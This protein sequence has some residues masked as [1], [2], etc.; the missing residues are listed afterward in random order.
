ASIDTASIGDVEDGLDLYRRL[1]SATLRT[2]NELRAR[3]GLHPNSSWFNP[4]GQEMEWLEKDIRSFVDRTFANFND[5]VFDAVLRFL[6][7]LLNE[8]WE[9]NELGAHGRFLG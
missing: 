8:F 6:L 4:Y 2:F 5:G 3:T 1:T 7:E 9:S